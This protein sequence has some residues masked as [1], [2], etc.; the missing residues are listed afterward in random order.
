[1]VVGGGM[2]PLFGDVGVCPVAGGLGGC[3]GGWRLCLLAVLE[4]FPVVGS[5]G[6]AGFGRVCWDDCG[7]FHIGE[8]GFGP[9]EGVG[10]ESGIADGTE[11]PVGFGR[12]WFPSKLY[13]VSG[14][15]FGNGGE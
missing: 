14:G 1:M 9:G 13:G 2:C 3:V 15:L 12:G 6:I 7:A 4:A 8:G 11:I 5:W 10:V